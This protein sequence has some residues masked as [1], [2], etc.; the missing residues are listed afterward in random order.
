[1][2]QIYKKAVQER[3]GHKYYL[4]TTNFYAHI[5][6]EID[7]DTSAIFNQFYSKTN[8]LPPSLPKPHFFK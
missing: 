8:P 3:L 5:L 7:K 6:E 1:M 2:I 4:T